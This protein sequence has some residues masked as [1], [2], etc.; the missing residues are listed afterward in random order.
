MDCL[1][2]RNGELYGSRISDSRFGG[3]K[4]G[5]LCIPSQLGLI[6]SS[7]PDLLLSASSSLIPLVD[8]GSTDAVL[9]AMAADA[10]KPVQGGWRPRTKGEEIALAWSALD[11]F[12]VRPETLPE[13]IFEHPAVQGGL[14]FPFIVGGFSPFPIWNLGYVLG[15]VFDIRRFNSVNAY[16][17]F[18]R[19]ARRGD[20]TLDC[21]D[22]SLSSSMPRLFLDLS[23][24][25]FFHYKLSSYFL[26]HSSSK[27]HP[28][29]NDSPFHDSKLSALVWSSF[30]KLAVFVRLVWLSG[31]DGG[32]AFDPDKFF[33]GGVWSLAFKSFLESGKGLD[34]AEIVVKI[35]S[36][37]R[38]GSTNEGNDSRSE[39]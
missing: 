6:R 3:A 26:R 23:P 1:F 31:L 37:L 9:D 21:G 11:D 14:L 30:R 39:P 25:S 28:S 24:N 12:V 29:E 22:R 8:S 7:K 34:A 17:S 13:L 15:A 35:S 38:G 18:F 4:T 20:Y 33:G 32:S 27:L 36:G 16:F 10:R 2:F 5:C 19:L